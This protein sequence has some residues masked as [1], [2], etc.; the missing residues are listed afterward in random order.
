MKKQKQKLEEEF[1]QTKKE[2]EDLAAKQLEIQQKDK[3]Y[4]NRL[5]YNM[6]NFIKESQ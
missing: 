2:R 1:S 5:R 6:E 4:Q 3:E